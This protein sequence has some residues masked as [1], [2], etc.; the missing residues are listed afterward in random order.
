MADYRAGR[1]GPPGLLVTEAR[2]PGEGD[3]LL[4]YAW[5]GGR[6]LDPVWEGAALQGSITALSVGD[7]D[8]DGRDDI[9]VAEASG[10][11]TRLIVYSSR[12]DALEKLP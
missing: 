5:S 8:A 10:G 9:V 3:R 11:T 6:R 2:P 1:S 4:Y 7:L 12:P